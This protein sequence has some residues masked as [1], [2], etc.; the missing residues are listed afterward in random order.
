VDPG[1]S[2]VSITAVANAPAGQ[3]G[4]FVVVTPRDVRG[5]YLGPF[6][7]DEVAIK[8]STGTFTGPVA[9]RLDGSYERTVFYDRGHDPVIT[10]S[11]ND[12]PVNA[13]PEQKGL[14]QLG[15]L[16]LLVTVFVALLRKVGILK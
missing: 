16:A 5:E 13:C 11:V 14:A 2:T 15:C 9:S 12:T 10:V 1:V 4:Q 3:L 8:A 6:R 7:E